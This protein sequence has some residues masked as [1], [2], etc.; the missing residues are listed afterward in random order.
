M[1]KLLWGLLMLSPAAAA[2]DG[3][4]VAEAPAALVVSDAQDGIFRP[5][6]MPAVGAYLD[7]EHVALGLRLRAGLLGNGHAPGENLAD[8][9][10][11]GLF[12]AVAAIRGHGKHAWIE[13]A[14]GGGITGSDLVPTVE[15]GAGYAVPWRGMEVGPSVRYVRVISR[16]EM[17]A[18]G[19]AELALVGL[20]VRFG[21]KQPAR[22]RP[23]VREPLP[24]PVAPPVIEVGTDTPNDHDRVV[25]HVAG[26]AEDMD[27]CPLVAGVTVKTDRIILDEQ[28]FFE[29][30]RARVR[31]AGRAALAEIAKLWADHPEWT[32]LVIEGHADV[33]GTDEHNLELSQLRADR[34][35]DVLIAHGCAPAHLTTIGF[36]RTRPR[37][38]ALTEAD[39]QKNRRVELVIQRTLVED[40]SSEPNRMADGGA[41]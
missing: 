1:R 33:R 40:N 20:D 21:V 16:D 29:L 30:D 5:G 39:H 34:V 24:A 9:G 3:W 7:T 6:L 19:T 18:F 28:V 36:G 25:E 32:A 35:R 41:R 23:T 38:E 26:C 22:L 17:D 10:T 2:A 27:G 31:S 15:L 12:T 13:A 4:L 8:P 11:G 14:A 37:V